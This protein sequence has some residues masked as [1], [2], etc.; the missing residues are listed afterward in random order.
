MKITLISKNLKILRISK[1]WTLQN[2]ANLIH[3]SL[4]AYHR[5]ENK[6]CKSLYD[7]IDKFCEIYNIKETDLLHTKIEIAIKNQEQTIL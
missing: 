2:V 3:V 7:H 5:M 4:S 1:G 6:S